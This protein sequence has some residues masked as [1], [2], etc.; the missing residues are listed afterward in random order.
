MHNAFIDAMVGHMYRFEAGM[1][2]TYILLTDKELAD[3]YH[4]YCGGFCPLTTI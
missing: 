3:F 4:A 2:V 1:P